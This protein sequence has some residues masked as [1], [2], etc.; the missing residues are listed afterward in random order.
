MGIDKISQV[1]R[2]VFLVRFHSVES[3]LKVVEDGVQ[4]FDKK[5]VV[6]KPWKSEIDMKKEMVDKIPVWIQLTGLDIKYWGK[7]ALTKI[8]GLVGKPLRVDKATTKNERL[9]FA[10]VLEKI[11]LNH[12]YPS[13]IMFENEHGKIVEQEIH[14]EWKPTLCLKYKNFGHD[15]KECRKQKRRRRRKQSGTRRNRTQQRLLQ[16]KQRNN[17]KEILGL[18]VFRKKGK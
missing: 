9:S 3:K 13:M 7:R 6:V 15:L 1:N 5:H 16:K 14:Y 2:E 10:R 17:N 4:M 18:G 11:S 12:K 8:D